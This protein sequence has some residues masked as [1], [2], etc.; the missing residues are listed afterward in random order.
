MHTL[1]AGMLLFVITWHLFLILAK[2][3]DIPT[4]VLACVQFLIRSLNANNAVLLLAQARLFDEAN[5]IER[6]FKVIDAQTDA[7]LASHGLSNI[8][9]ILTFEH[10]I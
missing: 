5:L 10:W 4:L 8:R 2:K 7:V 9:S 1:Y 3:Y 6:C